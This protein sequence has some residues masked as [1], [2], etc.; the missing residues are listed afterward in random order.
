MCVVIDINAFHCVFDGKSKDFPEFK[1]LNR[2]LYENPR[3]KLVYGG[4]RYRR[5]MAALKKYLSYLVELRRMSRIA[6]IEDDSVDTKETELATRVGR[7]DFNDAHIVAIFAVSGCRV[8][9]S[10]DKHLDKYLKKPS[11]YPRG[12][13]TPSI[14]RNRSHSHLLC[15]ANLVELRNR[16]R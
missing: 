1:P 7:A 5:E 16:K 4:T 11:F 3:A 13:K 12:Q 10:K 9:C 15:N 2:W 8:F 14:Y 6:E